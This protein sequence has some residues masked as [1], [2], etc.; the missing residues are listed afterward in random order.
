M[1][2]YSNMIKENNTSNKKDAKNPVKMTEAEKSS[3]IA[4]SH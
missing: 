4:D 1:H 2:S 3:F